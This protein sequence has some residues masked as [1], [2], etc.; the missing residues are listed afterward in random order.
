MM[1][2]ESERDEFATSTVFFES[3]CIVL[4]QGAGTAFFQRFSLVKTWTRRTSE[5]V[6]ATKASSGFFLKYSFFAFSPDLQKQKFSK[7]KF[8]VVTQTA[9]STQCNVC[10]YQAR[11]VTRYSRIIPHNCHFFTLTQFLENKIYTEIYTVN[12]QF[13]Q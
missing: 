8:Q 13:T 3:P 10:R 11:A 2:S 12:C 9:L 5:K 4:I 6:K 7:L 1:K